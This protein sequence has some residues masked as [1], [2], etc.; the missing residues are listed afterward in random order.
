MTAAFQHRTSGPAYRGLSRFFAC[1]G[2]QRHGPRFRHSR[3][4]K[5]LA[6]RKTAPGIFLAPTLETRPE[7]TTQT[8]GLHKETCVFGYDFASGCAVAP[9]STTTSSGPNWKEFG[10]G[11]VALAGGVLGAV[12]TMAETPLA[13][14]VVGAPLVVFTGTASAGAIGY[15]LGNIVA[16]FSG[17]PNQQE[18]MENFP[19]SIL[20]AIARGVG[21]QQLQDT[22]GALE[23]F[24][25]LGESL[26]AT[27]STVNSVN[28]VINMYQAA[29]GSVHVILVHKSPTP[30]PPAP[31]P[32]PSGP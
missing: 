13:A 1:S 32:P 19:Q 22:V 6:G 18:I 5:R 23:S 31:P 24:Q 11:V 12:V 3:P 26:N 9:N 2:T 10:E 29:D 30:P 17:D 27:Q 21:G 7:A 20:Q 8:L 25:S 28:N 15:G 16:A 4:A 14:T